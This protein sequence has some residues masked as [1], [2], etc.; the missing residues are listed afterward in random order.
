MTDKIVKSTKE[1]EEK[2]EGVTMS[3]KER[4]ET[5]RAF[6]NTYRP[7]RCNWCTHVEKRRHH[8]GIH[9][10]WPYYCTNPKSEY[11]DT[12]I[13][14]NIGCNHHSKIKES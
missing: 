2:M 4:I 8:D 10:P 5:M 1:H 11:F 3:E 7:W 14:N 9:G 12:N 13:E 6:Q